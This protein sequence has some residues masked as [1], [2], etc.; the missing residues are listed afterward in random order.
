MHFGI[1]IELRYW[2]CHIITWALI[3]SPENKQW[4]EIPYIFKGL[5][6]WVNTATSPGISPTFTNSFPYPFHDGVLFYSLLFLQSLRFI[7]TSFQSCSKA[8]LST[9][10]IFVITSLF[11]HLAWNS[12]LLLVAWKLNYPLPNQLLFVD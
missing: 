6:N 10:W 7:C 2:A 12:K 11:F 8:T 3:S 4:Y 9:S 1:R 5:N